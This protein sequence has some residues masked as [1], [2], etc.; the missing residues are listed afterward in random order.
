M[1]NGITVLTV[2]LLNASRS[3]AIPLTEDLH[4]LLN[5]ASSMKS[6]MESVR[7]TPTPENWTRL[8]K[9]TL[10]RLILF[11]KRRRGEAKDL[12]VK[13]YLERPDWNKDASGEMEMALLPVNKLLARRYHCKC[14]SLC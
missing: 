4:K 9:L 6:V 12:K 14:F 7:C 11:N 5:I 13:E 8:A 2:W 10:A 3:S 1:Q